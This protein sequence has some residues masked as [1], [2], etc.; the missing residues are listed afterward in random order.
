MSNAIFPTFPGLQYDRKRIPKWSTLVQTSV[1]G[2]ETRIALWSYPRY[3]YSVSF[4]LL[5]SAAAFT[6][7]QTLMGFFNLRQGSFDTWLFDDPEDD[8]VTAQWIGVG[9]G[10][11]LS[12]Q[13]VRSYGAWTDPIKDVQVMSNVYLAGVNQTSGWSVGS[14]GLL[15]FTTAPGSGVAIT[16]TFSYYWRCRFLADEYEFNLASY[17]WWECKKL[18]WISCK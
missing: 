11:T 14:T 3:T 13:L 10:H 12:F 17:Q 16:A 4:D 6:E 15:T 7:L 5:R 1:S 8:S 2:K 9:D 18:E